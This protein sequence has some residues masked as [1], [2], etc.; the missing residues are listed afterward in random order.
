MDARAS[1]GPTSA[2]ERRQ[3][4]CILFSVLKTVT[5][6][7]AACLLAA[8]LGT[9]C[10]TGSRE[11]AP[12]IVQPGAP[13]ESSHPIPA[14]QA[15]DLS[16]VQATAADIKFMQGMIG[17]HAQALEMTALL[18]T[19]TESDDMRKLAHRIELSQADEIK[20]MQRWLQVRGQAVPGEHDHHMHGAALMP[21]ML[22]PEEMDRLAAAKG[23]AFDRLFLQSMIKHHDGALV[24][25]KDLFA[26]P[27]AAQESEIFGFAS[28]VDAD[29]RMEIERMGAMLKELEK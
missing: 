8:S 26:T 9:A 23:P 21:G 13:G 24:M 14:A 11:A 22:T 5:Y 20:M 16:H 25:V 10:R 12:A 2:N 15:T 28:D 4:W 19:R 3:L 27:G 1:C 7:I 17:H 6:S 29:Q 18:S